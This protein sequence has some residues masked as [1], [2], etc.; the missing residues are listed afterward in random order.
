M[1]DW[2]RLKQKGISVL[3]NESCHFCYQKQWLKLKYG[4]LTIKYNPFA[5]NDTT[6][7]HTRQVYC[8]HVRCTVYTSGVLSTHQVYIKEKHYVLCTQTQQFA[9]HLIQENVLYK[10]HTMYV[11]HT[12]YVYLTHIL[13]VQKTQLNVSTVKMTGLASISK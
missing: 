5:P 3:I 9:M 1:L 4:H 12:H 7:I 2:S 11:T 8:L 6:C 13:Y 10:L